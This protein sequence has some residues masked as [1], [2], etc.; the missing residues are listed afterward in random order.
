V[1]RA[2][3]FLR[4]TGLEWTYRLSLEPGRLWR[5][6]LSSNPAF[7]ALLALQMLG[8]YRPSIV[9]LAEPAGRSGIRDTSFEP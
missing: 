6:Y 3:P 8:L 4:R 9:P 1:K 2:P 5:R 7:V